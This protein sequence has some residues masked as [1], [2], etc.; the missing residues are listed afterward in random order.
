MEKFK[1][2]PLEKVIFKIWWH[3]FNSKEATFADIALGK[4]LDLVRTNYPDSE[5]INASFNEFNNIFDVISPSENF[6][7]LSSSS[8]NPKLTY[9]IYRSGE[10]NVISED[11]N[12]VWDNFK[13]E[14]KDII[15]AIIDSNSNERYMDHF[16][17]SLEYVDLFDYED[18]IGG[19]NLITDNFNIS[20]L[21]GIDFFNLERTLKDIG[22]FLK[23]NLREDAVN[24]I[25]RPLLYR[26][27]N[28]FSLNIKIESPKMP[29]ELKDV[30]LWA[31]KA[32]DECSKLFRDMITDRLL[33][34]IK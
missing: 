25:F 4:F 17:L 22:L 16:H 1:N 24:F 28:M 32:H 14:I 19:D 33:N 27:K 8:S 29:I 6:K 15:K 12:Y 13:N 20:I 2:P 7:R 26:G 11:K 10:V 34:K 3:V 9:L 31:N 30:D 18:L 5:P 21:P 23:Y